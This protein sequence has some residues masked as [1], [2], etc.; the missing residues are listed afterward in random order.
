MVAPGTGTT[1]TPIGGPYQQPMLDGYKLGPASPARASGV[2]VET[3]SGLT[4]DGRTPNGGRDYWGAAVTP[5]TS[6]NR[7]ADNT[8]AGRRRPLR[9]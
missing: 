2:V 1:T 8:H 9:G 4:V 3:S 6:P 7:G 5:G